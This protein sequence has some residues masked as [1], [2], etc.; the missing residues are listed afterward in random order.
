MDK[1]HLVNILTLIDRYRKELSSSKDIQHRGLKY[2][3]KEDKEYWKSSVKFLNE[4]IKK[5]D[6]AIA[7]VDKEI[8]IKEK[9]YYL[10]G[11]QKKR[12]ES[13]E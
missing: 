13:H 2:L 4:K 6:K 8:L 10:S 1:R 7:A 3:N 5:L 12:G 9:R 11:N